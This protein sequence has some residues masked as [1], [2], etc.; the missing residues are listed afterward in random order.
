MKVVVIWKYQNPQKSQDTLGKVKSILL[1]KCD[2]FMATTRTCLLHLKYS[3]SD[4]RTIQELAEIEF[5]SGE[6]EYDK[7]ICNVLFT[8]VSF[9]KV[10]LCFYLFSPLFFLLSSV[11]SHSTCKPIF[12]IHYTSFFHLIHY[13]WCIVYLLTFVFWRVSVQIDIRSTFFIIQ[14]LNFLS[15]DKF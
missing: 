10:S 3:F 5:F 9:E 15:W 4:T 2:T 6:M 14:S 12:N 11:L 13:L 7:G 8:R 1:V